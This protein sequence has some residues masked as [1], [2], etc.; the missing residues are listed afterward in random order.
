M[1]EAFKKVGDELAKVEE[2]GI[3]ND[4][5]QAIFDTLRWCARESDFDSS[6][7]LYL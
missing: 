7:G 2:L 4:T 1:E 3:D 5:L 6:I